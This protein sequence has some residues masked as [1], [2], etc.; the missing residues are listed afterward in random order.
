MR[1]CAGAQLLNVDEISAASLAGPLAWTAPR[2]VELAPLCSATARPGRPS[3]AAQVLTE[4]LGALLCGVVEPRQLCI[5][6]G[7]AAW[8]VYLDIYVLD[9]G[10]WGF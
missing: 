5:D 6:A 7:K 10:G 9:A 3:E 4:Q 1:G 2:Q 8:A